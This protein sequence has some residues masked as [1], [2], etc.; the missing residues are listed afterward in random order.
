MNS[1]TSPR[2][3]GTG[4]RP[5]SWRGRWCQ[6]RIRAW[7][8]NT[9]PTKKTR[10]TATA[11]LT[12]MARMCSDGGQIFAP[13][14]L[15]G[16]HGDAR[17]QAAVDHIQQEMDLPGQGAGGHGGLAHQAQHGG[18]GHTHSG[19]DEILDGDGDDDGEKGTVEIFVCGLQG[20]PDLLKIRLV[21]KQWGRQPFP[22]GAA[23]GK[24]EGSDSTAA[25]QRERA[26]VR[27]LLLLWK[28][29]RF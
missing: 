24:G 3:S 1:R 29:G 16:Q 28:T 19:V 7:G 14:V 15:G 17:R 2:C 20:K 22:P 9:V 27:F 26:L 10:P 21:R 13:P 5:R 6:M 23:R 12:P 25:F 18:I 8:K 4:P 11:S